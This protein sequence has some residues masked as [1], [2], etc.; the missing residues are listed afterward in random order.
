MDLKSIVMGI[1]D[2][3]DAIS[4]LSNILNEDSSKVKNAAESIIPALLSGMNQNAQDEKELNSLMKAIGQHEDDDIKSSNFL[5]NVD[6]KDG[7]KILNHLLGQDKTKVQKEV[8]KSTGISQN[9]A[10]QLMATLAPLLMGSLGNQKKKEGFDTDILLKTLASIG[11]SQ[12]MGE[13]VKNFM[14]QDT[15]K[16]TTKKTTKKDTTDVVTDLIGKFLK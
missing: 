7:E 1:L 10:G 16:K 8:S 4:G 5:K 3:D 13:L 6:L 12:I 11:G 14:G 2:Q 9:S 15:P